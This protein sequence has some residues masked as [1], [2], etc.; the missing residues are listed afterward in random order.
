MREAS[1]ER[2]WLDDDRSATCI[3]VN[4]IR[5]S[6]ELHGALE[7]NHKG[8]KIPNGPRRL[9][10]NAVGRSAASHLTHF[11]KSWFVADLK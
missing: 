3:L 10:C 8:L 9:S 7:C 5:S 4:V 1:R 6:G 11:V 2:G